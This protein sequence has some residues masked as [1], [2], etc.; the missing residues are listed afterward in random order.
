MLWLT[1]GLLALELFMMYIKYD[2][3]NVRVRL[4]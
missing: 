2:F 1:L 4:M 3:L